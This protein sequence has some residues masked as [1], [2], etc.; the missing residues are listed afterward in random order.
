MSLLKLRYALLWFPGVI[1]L[2]KIGGC[3]I[4]TISIQGYE[5]KC[6]FDYE[7]AEKMTRH[8]PG[9]SDSVSVN[10][11]LDSDGDILKGWA[12]DILEQEIELACLDAVHDDQLEAQLAKEEHEMEAWIERRR[13]VKFEQWE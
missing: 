12:M 4:K 11:V 7:C 1:W 5:F 13:D 9:C 2:A 6:D 3:M 10:E 8:Y